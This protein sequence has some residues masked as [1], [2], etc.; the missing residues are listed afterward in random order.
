MS[1]RRARRSDAW[2]ESFGCLAIL[3]FLAF[4]VLVCAGVI[5]R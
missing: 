1:G 2:A 5:H 4:L 3:A